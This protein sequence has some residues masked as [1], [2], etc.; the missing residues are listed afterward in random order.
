LK[1]S[2]FDFSVE[3]S[4][5]WPLKNIHEG[6]K[7][8]WSRS[9][10]DGHISSVST[11]KRR[12]FRFLT[13]DGS[14]QRCRSRFNQVPPEGL[15]GQTIQINRRRR[16][17]QFRLG[18][19]DYTCNESLEPMNENGILTHARRMIHLAVWCHR[20]VKQSEHDHAIPSKFIQP[21]ITTSSSPSSI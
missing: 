1:I 11:P 14:I 3:I 9:A 10:W 2:N 21:S 18:R 7:A 19:P 15:D 16:R 13:A 5:N 6:V 20:L 17:Q 8:N 4:P 12:P